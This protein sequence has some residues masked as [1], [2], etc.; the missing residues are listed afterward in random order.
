MKDLKFTKKGQIRQVYIKDKV[1]TMIT[2]EM[3]Y[4]P[5]IFNL[6]KINE[7]KNEKQL[8]TIRE[9]GLDN[10]EK[11]KDENSIAIEIISEFDESGWRLIK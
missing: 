9:A 10:L 11:Y 6:D 2:P 3:S 1:I 4:Q 7:I 8:K 5:L